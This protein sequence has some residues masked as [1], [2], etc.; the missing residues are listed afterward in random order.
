MGWYLKDI[1]NPDCQCGKK[2][3]VT[4]YNTYNSPSGDYCRRCGEAEKKR[5]NKKLEERYESTKQNNG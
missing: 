5:Q 4:L 3:T 2:A 1:P